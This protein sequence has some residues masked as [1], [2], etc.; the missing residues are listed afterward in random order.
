[1][2]RCRLPGDTKSDFRTAGRRASVTGSVADA[3][4]WGDASV[5]R[6]QLGGAIQGGRFAGQNFAKP[7]CAHCANM[8]AKLP[9][10]TGGIRNRLVPTTVRGQV[11]QDGLART[12]GCLACCRNQPLFG[13]LLFTLNTHGGHWW[14]RFGEVAAA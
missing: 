10:A 6:A 8:T 12:T 4:G 7:T 9:T 14:L 13:T 2:E 1:M 5:R 3:G 11:G